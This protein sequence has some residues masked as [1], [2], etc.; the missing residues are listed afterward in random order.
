MEAGSL[1][2]LSSGQARLII[3]RQAAKDRKDTKGNKLVKSTFAT[4]EHNFVPLR[5]TT[6]NLYLFLS[7]LINLY[8]Y[9]SIYL[10]LP[11]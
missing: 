7:L 3:S 11:H 5:E 1:V 9:L 8:T 6:V 4:F 10:S 2:F